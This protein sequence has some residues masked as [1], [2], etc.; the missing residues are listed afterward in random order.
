MFVV[1]L[2]ALVVALGI[3]GVQ[4]VLGEHDHAEGDH[5]AAHVGDGGVVSLFASVRFW[6]FFLL[7]FGLPGALIA[8]FSLAGAVATALI[9]AGSGVASGLFAVLAIRALMGS[10]SPGA[11]VST[12]AIGRTG[13]VLLECAPGEV[14]RVRIEVQGRSVDRLATTDDG[15][16]ARGEQV[17]VE[18]V[19]GDVL[20]VSKVPPELSS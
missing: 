16:I 2:A 17:L 3:L 18:D 9:A 4:L 14:G 13:R 7:G 6:I 10:S 12:D 19:R 8:F 20:H 1:Y 5:D 11:D 15:V